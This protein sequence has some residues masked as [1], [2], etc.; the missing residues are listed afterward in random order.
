VPVEERWFGRSSVRLLHR[1]LTW[2]WGILRFA[3]AMPE[4]ERLIGRTISHCRVIEKL[5]GARSAS[6]CKL[7]ELLEFTKVRTGAGGRN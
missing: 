6:K 5:R 3:A 7:L 4:D 1:A 2:V